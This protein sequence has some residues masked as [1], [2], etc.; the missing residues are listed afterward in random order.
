[1]GA[2]EAFEQIPDCTIF[3]WGVATER[4]EAWTRIGC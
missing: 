4:A 3:A 2:L 1:M